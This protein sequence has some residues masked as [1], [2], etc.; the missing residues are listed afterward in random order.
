MGIHCECQVV[1]SREHLLIMGYRN[2]P[3]ILLNKS[4]TT[5]SSFISPT[6]LRKLCG[7]G[8]H[9]MSIGPMLIFA[10]SCCDYI[11]PETPTIEQAG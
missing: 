5:H 8:M 2:F 7:N 4:M 6:G 10:L 3:Y 9:A 1:T 11:T